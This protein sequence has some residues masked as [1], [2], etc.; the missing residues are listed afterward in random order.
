M[1]L[2]VPRDSESGEARPAATEGTEFELG[3][4][5]DLASA[6][7]V[8]YEPTLGGWQKRAFDLIVVSVLLVICWPAFLVAAL[9]LKLA[10]RK[11]VFN[12]D[13]CIGYGGRSFERLRFNAA[14]PPAANNKQDEPRPADD[15]PRSK[16]TRVVERLP[17]LVN[18]LR[19]DMSL[20]GPSPLLE[21][22]LD[23]LKSG[24]RYYISAR[25]GV[26][27]IGRLVDREHAETRY[28]AY[29]LSWSLTLDLQI[30]WDRLRGFRNRGRLWKPGIK[31]NRI[32][33][34]LAVDEDRKVVVRKR[35]AP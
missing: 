6:S 34:G 16:L 32:V 31:L 22:S 33:P 2:Q 17:E 13:S 3:I 18:V 19:G 20:V 8:S 12:L 25:P 4:R 15:Q 21:G 28:K 11:P 27:G 7:V 5:R 14:P 9:W 35:T 1:L 24:R 30:I 23:Q 10:N 29:A 26:F